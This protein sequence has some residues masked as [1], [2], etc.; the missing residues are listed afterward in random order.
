[1]V[2]LSGREKFHLSTSKRGSEAYNKLENKI[3]NI[4]IS[5]SLKGRATNMVT[6]GF[7]IPSDYIID[8]FFHLRQQ[9]EC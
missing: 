2:F 3:V 5:Q 1:M 8:T 4:N 9:F 6:E 7:Y